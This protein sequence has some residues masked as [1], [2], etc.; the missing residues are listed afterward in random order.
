M[1]LYELAS[2]ASGNNSHESI[3]HTG[4]VQSKLYGQPLN[5]DTSLLKT[6]FFVPAE[7]EPLHFL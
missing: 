1:C 5:T 4:K 2:L 7:R 3:T 6:V